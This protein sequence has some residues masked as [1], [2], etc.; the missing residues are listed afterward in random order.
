MQ[1]PLA[2]KKQPS[3][4]TISYH[5]GIKK[6]KVK[7]EIAVIFFVA[8]FFLLPHRTFAAARDVEHY[9]ILITFLLPCIMQRLGGFKYRHRYR[10]AL[11]TK[12]GKLP[13]INYSFA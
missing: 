6:A 10:I 9:M 12:G 1:F 13:E 3:S 5:R 11:K 8:A 7:Q 2:V 4:K